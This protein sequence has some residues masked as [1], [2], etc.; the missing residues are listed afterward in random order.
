[1]YLSNCNRGT[2]IFALILNN[3]RVFETG[4]HNTHA[5]QIKQYSSGNSSSGGR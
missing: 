2:K 4:Q 3:L 5:R 1:M